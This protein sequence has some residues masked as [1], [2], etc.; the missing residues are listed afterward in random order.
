MQRIVGLAEA[1]VDVLRGA[2]GG[3]PE[4]M[5]E[6]AGREQAGERAQE[7]PA[8]VLLGRGERRV[9][10]PG[11]RAPAD[12][13]AA[14][15]GREQIEAALERDPE[16]EAGAGAE[17][18]QPHAAL[19]TVGELQAAR[20]RRS[21]PAPRSAPPARPA[22][23]RAHTISIAAGPP[24]LPAACPPRSDSLAEVGD[25]PK[26]RGPGAVGF[27]QRR[28][29]PRLIDF[30]MRRER[31]TRA[32]RAGGGRG[33][34]PRARDRHRLGPQPAVLSARGRGG[35]R[36]RS[37][38]RAAGAGAHAH[39]LGA[40]PGRAAPR[41]RRGSCRSTTARSTAW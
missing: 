1:R 14:I 7:A 20:R 13:D 36:H 2:G 22:S 23:A 32:A 18:E 21:G 31:L 10:R 25:R 9:A 19:G 15:L 27:Y 6:P 35:A 40:L 3:G 16:G 39:R 12:R 5:I 8:A 17:L 33:P 4:R 11:R 30:A 26:R 29:L 41:Q 28:I 34:G 38:A 24:R 37:V